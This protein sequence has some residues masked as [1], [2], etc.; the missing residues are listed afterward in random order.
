MDKNTD[1]FIVS[2]RKYRPATF[3]SVIGQSH[4]TST[5]QNA[6]VRDKLAHAYLFCG[7]RGVGKTTCARIVAKTINCLNRTD[8]NEACDKCDSCVAFNEG[9]SFNIHEMDAASNT[10]VENIRSL[11]EQVRVLPQIGRYS[12]YIIDEVH[13]LSTSAFNAFLKTLEEPPEH[14][15][16]IL[17]TTE[18]HKILPTILSRCQIYDFKR[19]TVQDVVA[20]LQYIS[21]QEGVVSDDESL[22][23]IAAKADG[24]MRDALSM[25]DKV[26]S[27]CQGTLTSVAV[28]DA[29]NILDYDTYF[30]VVSLLRSGEI[31]NTLLK[32]DEVLQRGFDSQTFVGGLSS[33]LRDILVASNPSTLKLLEVSG[34]VAQKFTQQAKEADIAFIF[35]SLDILSKLDGAL[36]TSLNQRLSCEIALL[37]IAN[38]S[39]VIP[40]QSPRQHHLPQAIDQSTSSLASHSTEQASTTVQEDNTQKKEERTNETIKQETIETSSQSIN[41]P[42]TTEPQ[43]QRPKRTSRLGTSIK[44]LKAGLMNGADQSEEVVTVVEYSKRLDSDNEEAVIKACKQLAQEISETKPR[45]SIALSEAKI[46][47]QKISLEVMSEILEEEIIKQKHELL[48]SL[49]KICE[50]GE[51]DFTINVMEITQQAQEKK[52]YVKNEDKLEYLNSQNPHLKGFIK[53]LGLHIV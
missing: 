6:I 12:V 51:L 30:S 9:S 3:E 45:I 46:V 26:V 43:P 48:G 23:M 17:A 49:S 50:V 35:N 25:F 16:F 8:K 27:Y 44:E 33:H 52:I 13:M 42:I 38:L 39:G 20:Y 32:F 21:N 36:K 1:K 47:D 24:C 19:I 34:S 22:H 2:A 53:D 4:I 18:K 7:P 29:L 15:V 37:K 28:S 5:L 40:T 31:A 11:N 41:T 10:S 14:V